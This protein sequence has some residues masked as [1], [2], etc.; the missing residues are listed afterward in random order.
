MATTWRRSAFLAVALSLCGLG[1]WLSNGLL[2]LHDHSPVGSG[3][4]LD[5]ITH[6]CHSNGAESGQCAASARSAWSNFRL[7]I[8]GHPLDLPV[9]FLGIAYFIT[10][11]AWYGFVGWARP[12]WKPLKWFPI[13]LFI[14]GAYAS[15]FFVSLMAMG[16]VPWCWGCASVHLI[17]ALLISTVAW[18]Q[19]RGAGTASSEATINLRQAL[20]V[21]VLCGFL[22]GGMY[23]SRS[24]RL[25]L[26]NQVSEL[27]TYEQM[28]DSLQRD[29]KVMMDA[30]VDAPLHDVRLRADERVRGTTHQLVIYLDYECPACLMTEAFVHNEIVKE[31]G[32]KLNV[33]VRHYPICTECNP[34]VLR[35]LHPNACNAAYAAEAARALGGRAAFDRMT[36]LLF[37]NASSLSTAIGREMAS[38]AGVDPDQFMI[39]LHD[40]AMQK[41]VAEDVAEAHALGVEDTPTMFL[42]GRQV[43]AICMA[44]GFW[45]AVAKEPTTERAAK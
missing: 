13:G 23:V 10:L 22:I 7:P 12:A 40:P 37:G 35:T 15:L 34:H 24:R 14:V 43:P 6:L 4:A 1:G 39:K 26:E 9:A 11:G 30:Y 33:V 45:E 36:D 3:F 27:P 2:D 20:A 29:P 31:F 5:L 28:I 32:D 21:L 17:N 18:S 16:R 19:R 41:R 8:P 42:D 44:R 25:R 38:A